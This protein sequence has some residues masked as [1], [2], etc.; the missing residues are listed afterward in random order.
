MVVALDAKR[1]AIV[2]AVIRGLGIE[3]EE[4]APAT[5]PTVSEEEHGMKEFRVLKRAVSVGELL[6]SADFA[7]WTASDW[8]VQRMPSGD[9]F[10]GVLVHHDPPSFVAVTHEDQI[11]RLIPEA[12]DDLKAH[13]R[14]E[15]CANRELAENET[16]HHGQPWVIG[17]MHM[18]GEFLYVTWPHGESAPYNRPGLVAGT[19]PDSARRL[20]FLNKHRPL[21]DDEIF[22]PKGNRTK[23]LSAYGETVVTATGGPWDPYWPNTELTGQSL[24]N[25]RAFL[26]ARLSA[27]KVRFDCGALGTM[28]MAGS[29]VRFAIP[30]DVPRDWGEFN[31][32]FTWDLFGTTYRITDPIQRRKVRDFAGAKEEKR[33]EEITVTVHLKGIHNPRQIGQ[34]VLGARFVSVSAGPYGE[35]IYTHHGEITDFD[36]GGFNRRLPC[37]VAARFVPCHSPASPPTPTPEAPT[38]ACS[39]IWGSCV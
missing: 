10:E 26:D 31:T 37:G 17:V 12:P 16:R 22:T 14:R 2:D 8:G 19:T 13:V 35:Y 36:R 34:D 3:P 39:P 18:V 28:T 30:G 5:H 33:A 20:A 27:D 38:N 4:A 25:A 29:Y 1:R 7:T 21:A 32:D 15:V 24:L 23:L 11:K 6:T 9:G